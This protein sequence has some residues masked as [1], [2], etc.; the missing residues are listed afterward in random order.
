MELLHFMWE[1]V[2]ASIPL[3]A[4]D[5]EMLWSWAL[6]SRNILWPRAA[7]GY[8]GGNALSCGILPS[9]SKCL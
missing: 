9:Q 8:Q 4:D 2:S 1:G 3:E 6:P 5:H 7:Q